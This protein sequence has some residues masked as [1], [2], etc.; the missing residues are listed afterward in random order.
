M[1]MKAKEFCETLRITGNRLKDLK[2]KGYFTPEN[3]GTGNRYEYTENDISWLKQLIVLNC[4]GVPSSIACKVCNGELSLDDVLT[5]SKQKIEEEIQK[6]EAALQ[7]IAMIETERLS[8]KDLQVDALFDYIREQ[9][10]N[11]RVYPDPD[12]EATIPMDGYIECP[13]CHQ[14][15][16]DNF[17]EFIVNEYTADED[18]DDIRMGP[19]LMHEID[20]GEEYQCKNCGKY[21]RVYGWIR[22]YPLGAYD[23]EELKAV[24]IE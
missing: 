18:P 23:S 20:T 3:A 19:D 5:E 13:Y 2:K 12:Y 22:E 17:G 21:I 6:K 14:K 10:S 15:Y 16:R 4:A 11:G 1:L 8:N 7:L 9:K 24:P